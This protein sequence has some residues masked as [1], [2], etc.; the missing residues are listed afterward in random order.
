MEV[1]QQPARRVDGTTPL[2]FTS[3]EQLKAHYRAVRQRVRGKVPL[4]VAILPKPPEPEPELP[5]PE[6]GWPDQPV[7][8]VALEPA[9]LPEVI[10]LPAEEPKPLRRDNILRAVAAAAKVSV[11][12]LKSHLRSRHLVNARFVYY[13]IA[14]RYSG[15]S[16]PQIGAAAGLRDHSTVMH[17]LRVG[18]ERFRELYPIYRE[19]CDTLG[20]PVPDVREFLELKK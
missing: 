17:G 19:A 16:L 14:R 10:E 3:S 4:P 12:E 11:I 8:V 20:V 2:E 18:A 6:H 15:C 5:P 9:R 1:A 13:V 7:A